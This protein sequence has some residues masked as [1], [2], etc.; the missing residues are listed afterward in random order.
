MKDFG[1][2]NTFKYIGLVLLYLSMNLPVVGTCYA[3]TVHIDSLGDVTHITELD[4]GGTLYNVDFEYTGY[5]SVFPDGKTPFFWG[6]EI[7]TIAATDAI[8]AALN[9]TDPVPQRIR[10]TEG[11]AAIPAFKLPFEI[12]GPEGRTFFSW[13]GVEFL[14]G[15]V[16]WERRLT[17]SSGFG[18][19]NYATFDVVPIPAALPLFGSAIVVLGFTAWRNRKPS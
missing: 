6:K 5:G 15:D 7:G 19:A 18:L 17:T 14:G 8:N 13:N 3:A 16:L 9:S 1:L 10:G 4:V 12:G 2:S 11:R